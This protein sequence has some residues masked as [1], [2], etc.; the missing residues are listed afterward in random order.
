MEIPENMLK[1]CH[2]MW[3][4]SLI[5]TLLNGETIDASQAM[6]AIR[7]TWRTRAKMDIVHRGNNLYVCRFDN[8]YDKDRVVEFQPWK[9]LGKLVLMQ[10]FSAEMDP[11]AFRFDTIPLW[12]NFKG[13]HLEHYTPG[14]VR[15]IGTT[16][17]EVETVLPEVVVPRSEEG[18][19]ARVKV[20]VF[21]PLKQG[22]PAKTLHQGSVW[23]GFSY[24]LPRNVYCET[25][26]R[27]GHEQGICTYSPLEPTD[28]ISSSFS[29][30]FLDYPAG[31]LFINDVEQ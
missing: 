29:S 1:D 7:G 25:C 15:V 18:Y 10:P 21:E 20:K 30:F 12:M 11:F 17:G 6:K 27:L 28:N 24:H 8:M 31:N 9:V 2:A 26:N 14:I 4:G 13:L 23:V 16:A 3:A 22:T 5:V 19:R